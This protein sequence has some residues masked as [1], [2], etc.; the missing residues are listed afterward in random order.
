MKPRWLTIS[1]DV[2]Y[3][4]PDKVKTH[5]REM[6]DSHARRWQARSNGR[7]LSPILRRE[8]RRLRVIEP[9][10]G[11]PVAGSHA[12]MQ[13]LQKMGAIFDVR[14]GIERLLQIGEGIGMR[15]EIDLH[16]ANIKEGY[17]AGVQGLARPRYR[18]GFAGEKGS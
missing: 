3:P 14:R 11:E 1:I 15:P 8:R 16:A 4:T 10:R 18:L 9:N 5:R 2:Q 7:N 6:S 12:I 17:G 13:M